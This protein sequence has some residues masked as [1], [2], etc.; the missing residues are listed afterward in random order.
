MTDVDERWLERDGARVHYEVRRGTD[1]RTPLLLTHGFASSSTMWE[2]TATALSSDRT[3]I[4]WDIRGHGLTSCRL[5]PK[6]FTQ[7]ACLND[8]RAIL[9]ECGVDRVA[10]GGLSLGGYLSLALGVAHPD[11]LAALVLA[12]TG[13]G[14]RREEG[15]ARWNA[16][17]ES[18]ASEFERR[19]LD[20]LSSSPET[21]L[22]AHDAQGLALAARGILTQHDA[23][24]IEALSSIV[25]PTLVLVG[26]LDRPFLLGSEY[27]AKR[28]SSARLHVVVHAGHAANLDQPEEF[29]A[30]VSGFLSDID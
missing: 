30:V 16:F 22:G 2:A 5:D 28:I 23:T 21:R 4:T 17:C 29:N 6:E 13:P 25:A 12:D 27:M 10:L 26:E 18:Q 20:A 11:R 3:V 19:G 9:D 8:M 1:G 7:A 15:R 24:V 14:Y